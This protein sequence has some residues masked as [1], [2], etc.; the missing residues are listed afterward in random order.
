MSEFLSRIISTLDLT[1]TSERH[2]P[3]ITHRF[4]ITTARLVNAPWSLY[5][6]FVILNMTIE[7]KY[8]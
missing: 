1:T 8:I 6:S 2:V 4:G 5:S 3:Y 7:N